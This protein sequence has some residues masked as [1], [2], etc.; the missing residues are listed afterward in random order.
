MDSDI[1]LHVAD[2]TEPITLTVVEAALKPEQEKT[3][4]PQYDDPLEVL[5][6]AGKVL[7]RVTVE[8]I[9]EPTEEE[10]YTENGIYDVARIGSAIIQVPQG[11]FP[12][13]TLPID[14]NGIFDVAP[15]QSVDI[16]VQQT[17]EPVLLDSVD[18]SQ[19]AEPVN[20]IVFDIAQYD[21]SKY[22][23][24]WI[25]VDGA[26]FSADDWLY[27][28]AGSNVAYTSRGITRDFHK[29]MFVRCG[30][31]W[32]NMVKFSSPLAY[33][34][35]GDSTGVGNIACYPYSSSTIITEGTANLYAV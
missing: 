13:G 17:Y 32:Y 29:V 35:V 1:T 11:V 23:I 3:V 31:T 18:V 5:P 8:P 33:Q 24:V 34:L 15:Y 2:N 20:R 30:D 27:F 4:S 21:L 9:P 12:A 7:S 16:N 28:S 10:T 19:L 6:D 14:S 26:R 22:H 25:E